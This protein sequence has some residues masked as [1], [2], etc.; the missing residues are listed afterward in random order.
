MQNSRSILSGAD[1]AIHMDLNLHLILVA[2]LLASASPGPATLAIAGTSMASGRVAGLMLA[3]GITTGSLFWSA[4]AALGLGTAMHA[5]SWVFEALR[6]F[7][8]AYLIFLAYRSARSA[9]S[10]KTISPRS[11]TGSKT[12]LFTKGL[13]L[14]ITNPKAILFFGA[15]YSIGLPAGAAFSDLTLVIFAVGLQSLTIFHGY[16]LLFSSRPATRIYLGSRRVIEGLFTIAFGAAGLKI[17][18]ARLN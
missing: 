1:P 11:E 8:A 15:L 18:T 5:N 6:Y 7:G 10:G 16:A 17:L 4:A 2:A 13:L 14:H 12:A 3:A 9:V